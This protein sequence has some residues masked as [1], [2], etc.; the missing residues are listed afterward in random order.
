MLSPTVLNS[1]HS[2][3]AILIVLNSLRSTE[4][5]LYGV[6]EAIKGLNFMSIIYAI[7][8]ITNPKPAYVTDSLIL[9]KGNHTGSIITLYNVCLVHR[10][11]FSTYHEYIGGIL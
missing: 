4:P 1:L 3:D 11:V 5:T 10:G 8:C 2:T 9:A 6:I 7:E